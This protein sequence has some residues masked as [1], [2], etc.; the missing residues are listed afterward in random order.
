L[1]TFT[2]DGLTLIPGV[3][4]LLPAIPVALWIW[5]RG[6]DPHWTLMALLALIHIDLVIALTIFPIPIGGQEFYRVSRGLTFGDNFVPFST[7]LSQI[8]DLNPHVDHNARILVLGSLR[9]LGGN[10]LALAPLGIYGPALWPRLRNWRRFAL[11]AIAFGIGIETA[12][13]VGSLVEGFAYRITDVDPQRNGR[14]C[15]F[16]RLALDGTA[17]PGRSMAGTDHRRGAR[18]GREPAHRVES[19]AW[20]PI[21]SV[22]SPPR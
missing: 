8:A 3:W 22:A 6:S 5:R 14:H 13:F 11:V 12:Q 1:F 18:A 17:R 19:A 15:R 21:R 20:R 7:I 4:A 16:L 2:E 10:L 9:Q